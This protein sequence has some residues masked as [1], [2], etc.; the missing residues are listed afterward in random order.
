VSPHSGAKGLYV[1]TC[2]SFHGFKFFPVIGKY[3][4][5]MLEGTLAPEMEARWSWDRERPDS[6]QNPE[7]PNSELADLQEP[8]AR[9]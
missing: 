2:G 6:S 1:A 7:Y 4:A 5:Q 8:V 9:L 3:V